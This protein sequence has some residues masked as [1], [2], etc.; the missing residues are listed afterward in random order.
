MGE[1]GRFEV[2]LCNTRA[3]RLPVLCFSIGGG[4]GAKMPAR[5]DP[6]RLQDG[7]L[8]NFFALF[9]V[10]VCHSPAPSSA[11]L[12]VPQAGDLDVLRGLGSQVGVGGLDALKDSGNLTGLVVDRGGAKDDASLEDLGGLGVLL[13]E[14]LGVSRGWQGDGGVVSG[15]G[16][17]SLGVQEGGTPVRGNDEVAAEL[18]EV[19]LGDELL[20]GEQEGDP[21]ASRKLNGGG[22]VVD[23]VLLLELDTTV[24]TDL[25]LSAD[26]VQGVG[27]PGHEL[28]GHEVGLL[29]LG[30]GLLLDLEARWLQAELG[31]VVVPGL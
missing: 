20:D 31:D 24:A 26:L 16:S 13:L 28:G 4:E 30:H 29:A 21:L 22:G 12:S 10:V 23:A 19:A 18:A 27:Q 15:G 3:R 11:Q 1:R 2:V 5:P 7:C 14:L 17:P 9:F 25:E 8:R 6:L